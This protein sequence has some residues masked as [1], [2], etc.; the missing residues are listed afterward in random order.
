MKFVWFRRKHS[1]LNQH[2]GSY[3]SSPSSSI[4]QKP[5]ITVQKS[6]MT[7][8]VPK[9]IAPSPSISSSSIHKTNP[10]QGGTKYKCFS[11]ATATYCKYVSVFSFFL[12]HICIE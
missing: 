8:I 3:I 1:K 5:V 11:V 7:G 2:L 6:Q 10:C 4:V 9:P 12:L